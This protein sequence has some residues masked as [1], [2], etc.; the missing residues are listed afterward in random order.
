MHLNLAH[1]PIHSEG[2]EYLL[3]TLDGNPMMEGTGLER[4]QCNANVLEYRPNLEGTQRPQSSV[5]HDSSGLG[6]TIGSLTANNRDLTELRL[7]GLD[8]ARSS[9]AE[10]LFDALALDLVI[11]TLLLDNTCVDATLVAHLSL[12]RRHCRI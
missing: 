7:L 11:T 9:Q 6:T 3:R 2:A 5:I 12:T 8:L 10:D 4:N 1:I